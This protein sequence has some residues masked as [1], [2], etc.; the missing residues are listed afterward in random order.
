MKYQYININ[1]TSSIFVIFMNVT[2]MT[3]IM[4]PYK[5]EKHLKLM[6]KTVIPG[7]C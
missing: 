7:L 6:K 5:R 1:M 3:L 2:L 4:V